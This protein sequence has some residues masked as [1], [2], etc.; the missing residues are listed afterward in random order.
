DGA[1]ADVAP[2]EELPRCHHAAPLRLEGDDV[3]DAP[4]AAHDAKR[5]APF[6]EQRAR[7]AGLAAAGRGAARSSRSIRPQA[8]LPNHEALAVEERPRAGPRLEPAH[9]VVD[10][11]GRT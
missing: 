6:D 7:C 1:G 11:G 4:V 9:E 5:L 8:C 2:R 10:L 3:E